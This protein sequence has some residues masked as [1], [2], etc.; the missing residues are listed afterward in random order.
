[1]LF[2][3]RLKRLRAEHHLTQEDLSKKLNVGRTTISGYEKG[4]IKPSND[5]LM[6]MA[7]IFNCTT[8]YLLGKTDVRNYDFSRFDDPQKRNDVKLI[9]NTI[10][11]VI[12]VL[13]V[14]NETV[15]TQKLKSK[16]EYINENDLELIK[17]NINTCLL[18]I[19]KLLS[20]T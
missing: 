12:H 6:E 3:I 17:V 10:V 14:I 13:E 15:S 11:D 16:N 20:S 2:N 5:V 7:K 4:S 8:D 1:M 18:N 9:E 19:K